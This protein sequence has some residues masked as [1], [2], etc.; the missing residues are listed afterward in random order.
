M[1]KWAV[2]YRE[3]PRGRWKTWNQYFWN[4]DATVAVQRVRILP[5]VA[6]ARVVRIEAKPARPRGWAA[7]KQRV[8]YKR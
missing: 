8:H 1:A 6:E 7:Q 4:A 2:E 5:G 3:T